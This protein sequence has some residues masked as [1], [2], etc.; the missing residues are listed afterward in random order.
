MNEK[1][2]FLEK[3][4]QEGIWG[5]LWSLPEAPVDEDIMK[6]CRYRFGM[7]FSASPPM[8]PLNHTFTH[9]KLR[10]YPLVFQVMSL[11]ATAVQ[12]SE[13]FIWTTLDAALRS[14]IPTP[15]RKLLKSIQLRPTEDKYG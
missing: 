5:G 8:Q 13:T 15:I 9:F 3:R 6:H 14:A 12:P 11:T 4:P 10:I 7:E 1:K 2:V